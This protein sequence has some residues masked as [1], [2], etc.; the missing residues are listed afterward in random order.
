MNKLSTIKKY[1][2]HEWLCKSNFSFLAGA[3]HPGELLKRASVLGYKSLAF[4][5]FDGVYGLAR[6][7]INNR[8]LKKEGFDVSSLIYGAELHLE[9]DHDQPILLQ[10]TVALIAKSKKGYH[11][12]CK[13]FSLA[14]KDSKLKAFLSLSD[15]LKQDVSDL[16][17]I[18]PMRGAIRNSQDLSYIKDLKDHFHDDAYMALSRHLHPSEDVWVQRSLGLAK[19]YEL[20]TLFC[21]DV[22][23]HEPERKVMS[24]LLQAIRTNLTMDQAGAHF[25]PNA[26]RHC[27]DLSDLAGLFGG[28][29]DFEKS[30]IASRELFETC[31]FS[32][33]ELKYQYPKEMIP[34]GFTAQ[35]FLEK[36]TWEGARERF[37]EHLPCKVVQTLSRE[38]DLIEQL[39]FADY[40]LTVWDI[41]RWARHQNILCQGRGSA[42]NSS[43]C[44]ALGI[45][46]VD[47][48]LFDLLFE[49]FIS[50]ERGDPPDI[51]VDFEH[52]RREEVIQYI[53]RH[54]GRKRAAM[55]ANVITFKHKGALRAVGK[56]LGMD[57]NTLS[58]VAKLMGSKYFRGKGLNE[59]LNETKNQIDKATG[60]KTSDTTWR[61]W[62]RLSQELKG[63]PRH[64]GIH[65]G[66]FVLTDQ[67]INHLVAQEPATMEG[68]TVIQ[69]CKEDIEGLNF[70][71]ID[72]LALGMLTAVRKSFALLKDH[73]NR[74]FDLYDIPQED[75]ATYTMIQ[76][77]N[78]VGTFQIESRAQ[79]SML[80][81]LKPKTFY[82]LVIEIAI[83]RPG[84]IQGGVIHP[85]LKRRQ[86]IEPIVYP[87]ERLK[88]ILSRTLGVA[89]FQEQAMRIAIAVGDFT[90]GEANELRRHIGS[91]NLSKFE[92][93]LDP[94]VQKLERGMRR[95]N[96]AE[97]FIQQIVEH[98]KGFAHYGFPE[99]HSISFA[100]IA[101]AS[102][103]LKCH[104]PAAFFCSVL[105]SQPMG[106]YSPH[107]LLQAAG[108][109]GVEVLPICAQKSQW[110][111]SLEN[112]A[113][114]NRPP[115]F[116]IRLGLRLVNGLS[117]KAARHLVDM[118]GE[119]PFSDFD[120]LLRRTNLYRDD[121]TALAA[122]NAFQSFG[123]SRREAIWKAES[124]PLKPLIDIEETKIK[125][126]VEQKMQ[127]IQSDFMA[128]NT[129]LGPHP[130]QIIREDHWSYDIPTDKIIL[131]K[132][133][134]HI[135]R[136]HVIEAFGMILVKQAPPS[137]KGMVFVTMEDET[138]FINLAFTPQVYEQYFKIV[139]S[140]S[141]LLITGRMQKEGA[142]HSILVKKVH[143]RK[144]HTA[145][146]LNRGRAPSRDS[147]GHS[148]TG[149]DD[150]DNVVLQKP[151]GYF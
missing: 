82:D 97:E 114:N 9:P 88:P 124:V 52:E 50:M 28:F 36:V 14:H 93:R 32:F 109:D 51:D 34:Q 13:I 53:Y 8:D 134:E 80:P 95:N 96:I 68:R 87:D 150:R 111:N 22:F 16:A 74:P 30:L 29:P 46:S 60:I 26:E 37:G 86:G 125:W 23:F 135:P 116:A 137:A 62:G 105:N 101:Y 142:G 103:Y 57:E 81:R 35:S 143:K 77:A 31:Q 3:S 112:I 145:K 72:I 138:G 5:D 100:F 115:L 33:D 136:N 61:L 63:F 127:S 70:F 2:W 129:S 10:N 133:F 119:K 90:P 117:Q 132:N 120:D 104:Y 24:D 65:S 42:A 113:K 27:K 147:M 146:I 79:M 44:F 39:D 139:E 43:V 141:H 121:I 41:V 25:F 18:Q 48:T 55:V 126:S 76:K 12:L 1:G 75:E 102:C 17:L 94:W 20:P 49:R 54:Y 122:A 140:E 64:L 15:L 123:F 148:K 85:Y 98:M 149:S 130:T 84:P 56:A 92:Q 83:I 11:N 58:M 47:P 118:R 45:T 4:N 131:A 71:K 99:S 91:W 7:H 106:F 108:R 144:A 128:F 110:D 151:R 67:T 21:Q 78:T 66:G 73:Y 89:I 59:V 38:L 40:F 6:A 69:W 107:A 19:K